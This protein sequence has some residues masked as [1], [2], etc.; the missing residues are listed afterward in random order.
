[1]SEV[2]LWLPKGLDL[3]TRMTAAGLES[4]TAYAEWWVSEVGRWGTLYKVPPGQF[5][6]LAFA[7]LETVIP[8]NLVRQVKRVLIPDVLETDG[9]YWFGPGRPGK[10]LGYRLAPT[11]AAEPEVV[12][13]FSC[14]LSRKLAAADLRRAGEQER[15][16]AALSPLHR[17]LRDHVRSAW[18]TD[19]AKGDG[20]PGVEFLT[21]ERPGWFVV[22]G[23]GRVH[24]PVASCP[25]RLR[26]HLRLADPNAPLSLVDV[27]TSQP[28]LL[29]LVVGGYAMRTPGAA[30]P[31]ARSG[32]THSHEKPATGTQQT[33]GG[34]DGHLFSPD[35]DT[36]R[37]ITECLTGDLYTKLAN[38]MS[39]L[40][41]R[42]EYSREHAK[43]RWMRAVYGDPWLMDKQLAGRALAALYPQF[44]RRVRAMAESGGRG[45]LARSMQRLESDVVIGGVAAALIDQHPAVSFVT[46]HDAVICH[47]AHAPL[48]R[49]VFGDVFGHRFGVA[50]RLKVEPL[51][52]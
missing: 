10:C 7:H 16:A 20:H 28:L 49:Q 21:G 45:H 38:A 27:T 30:T 18:L 32:E 43:R 1:M 3:R 42:S 12:T 26:R 19:G 36:G 25:R 17:Q 33:D 29:G 4:R 39:V 46:V 8:R 44:F 2:K 14:S 22:C 5:V 34:R 40:S 31:P 23:Q 6:P 13:R 41:A 11:L 52:G 15:E 9:R 47:T 48:V 50:P 51:S 24:H 35:S 37:F